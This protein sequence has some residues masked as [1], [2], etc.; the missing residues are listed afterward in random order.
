[1]KL[2]SLNAI[3]YWYSSFYRYSM[4]AGC[5]KSRFTVVSRRNTE[6]ILVLFIIVLFSIWTTFFP[7][8]EFTIKETVKKTNDFSDKK[9]LF[10]NPKR[11]CV[12]YLW[13]MAGT[14]TGRGPPRLTGKQ[15]AEKDLK[16]LHFPAE[17][18]FGGITSDKSYEMNRRTTVITMWWNMSTREKYFP[19]LDNEYITSKRPEAHAQK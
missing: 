7:H 4:C 8:P 18:E 5:G 15:R 6:F 2:I 10:C 11:R 9:I 19:V 14:E 13:C 3:N 1:M 16:S 17:N 12:W